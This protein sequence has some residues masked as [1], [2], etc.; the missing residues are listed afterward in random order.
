MVGEPGSGKTRLAAELLTRML[1]S[2]VEEGTGY[3]IMAEH[4]SLD[5]ESSWY[6]SADGQPVTGESTDRPAT[7]DPACP[8]P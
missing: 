3:C 7:A 5:S 2:A 6:H 1:A 8:T 4:G